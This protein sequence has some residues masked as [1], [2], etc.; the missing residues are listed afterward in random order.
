MEKKFDILDEINRVVINEGKTGLYRT[1][2][3]AKLGGLMPE[4]IIRD[5]AEEI[6]KEFED[7]GNT[8]G[9]AYT[10]NSFE[11][12]GRAIELYEKLGELNGD[13]SYFEQAAFIAKEHN[14]KEKSLEC[15][16]KAIDIY[17]RKEDLHQAASTAEN[18]GLFEHACQLYCKD[19][20]NIRAIRIAKKNRLDSLLKNLCEDAIKK[21]KS[22]GDFK[23]AAY[24]AKAIDMNDDF[25]KLFKLAIEKEKNNGEFL[26]ALVLSEI[27]DVNGGLEDYTGPFKMNCKEII[28]LLTIEFD[29]QSWFGLDDLAEKTRIKTESY[30]DSINER[31]D[32]YIIN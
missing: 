25:K 18:A 20:N 9:A 13:A 24:A 7:Q 17:K 19:G 11:L 2:L 1:L 16:R 32:I 15:F 26:E 27:S 4:E 6:V 21:F 8:L 5:L 30:Q 31:M 29:I 14:F 3:R 28:K 22:E 12:Y 23:Y 10:A